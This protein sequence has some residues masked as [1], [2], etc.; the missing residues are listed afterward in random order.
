MSGN[1]TNAFWNPFVKNCGPCWPAVPDL[2]EPLWPHYLE[3][4]LR[5]EL[6]QIIDHNT[7]EKRMPFYTTLGELVARW[8]KFVAKFLGRYKQ[9]L[10]VEKPPLVSVAINS[11]NGR[12]DYKFTDFVQQR[13]ENVTIKMVFN[14]E[15]GADFVTVA[16]TWFYD[17]DRSSST[18][19]SRILDTS[20]RGP[21]MSAVARRAVL[22]QAQSEAFVESARWR[23][24]GRSELPP[25]R[26]VEE[27]DIGPALRTLPRYWSQP[28]SETRTDKPDTPSEKLSTALSGLPPSG[29]DLLS[30]STRKA[31]FLDSYLA[32]EFELETRTNTKPKTALRSKS[33]ERRKFR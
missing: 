27:L 8:S 31:T 28:E 33:A 3:F 6:P 19:Q 17:D 2:T 7:F 4:F 30:G 32:A 15:L 1:P 18:A 21:Q 12:K 16:T 20:F 14:I 24:S 10:G 5:F 11:V 29:L 25:L 23:V 9:T 22:T 26:Q 13:C